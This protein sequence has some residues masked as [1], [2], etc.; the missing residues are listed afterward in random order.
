[1]GPRATAAVRYLRTLGSYGYYVCGVACWGL[2]R[3]ENENALVSVCVLS[4]MLCILSIALCIVQ[5]Y[6]LYLLYAS[7]RMHED[8]S[9][10][11]YCTQW[12]CDGHTNDTNY[13]LY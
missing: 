5:L 2:F 12:Q 8:M 7:L 3:R 1:M 9:N 13:N 10:R 4:G 6:H 11:T